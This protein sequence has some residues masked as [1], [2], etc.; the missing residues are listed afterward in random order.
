MATWLAV[1]KGRL[2]RAALIRYPPTWS[3]AVPW[4]VSCPLG[5]GD[6]ILWHPADH[7]PEVVTD[8]LTW[9]VTPDAENLV[10]HLDDLFKDLP[11]EA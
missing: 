1:G 3:W 5:R 7:R 6:P 2:I 8:A 11:T 10:I 9:R 4:V